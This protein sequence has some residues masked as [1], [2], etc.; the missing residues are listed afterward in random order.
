MR[1]AIL[2]AEDSPARNQ[3]VQ[4]LENM[5][6]RYRAEATELAATIMT[7]ASHVGGTGQLAADFIDSVLT[8]IDSEEFGPSLSGPSGE[9]WESMAL[10]TVVLNIPGDA[11]TGEQS[12]SIKLF[13]PFINPQ[14][15]KSDQSDIR[16]NAQAIQDLRTYYADSPDYQQLI[17]DLELFARMQEKLMKYPLSPLTGTGKGK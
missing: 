12:K 7:T 6:E 3:A 17:T 9:D 16:L 10:T 4:A 2:D 15:G 1:M 5:R 11:E 8:N 14:T 13:E